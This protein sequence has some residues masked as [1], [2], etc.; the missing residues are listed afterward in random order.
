MWLIR[1]MFLV[2]L[3]FAL[4]A[5][6]YGTTHYFTFIILD[7]LF[8]ISPTKARKY[9]YH[10]NKLFEHGSKVDGCIELISFDRHYTYNIS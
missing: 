1:V 2:V 5:I 4:P 8:Y 9:P 6:T 7:Q 3:H 10:R